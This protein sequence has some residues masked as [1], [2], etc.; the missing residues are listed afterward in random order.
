[1]ISPL[2]L[3]KFGFFL[4]SR[5]STIECVVCK[6]KLPLN[7]FENIQSDN[8]GNNDNSKAIEKSLEQCHRELCIYRTASS[9]NSFFSLPLLSS[10]QLLNGLLS[11]ASSIQNSI[12]QFQ[13]QPQI[14]LNVPSFFNLD[15]QKFKTIVSSSSSSTTT[16][17]ISDNALLLASF[18]ISLKSQQSNLLYC[19]MCQHVSHIRSLLDTS[20]KQN[21][22]NGSSSNNSRRIKY[23]STPQSPLD[24]HRWFCAWVAEGK[25]INDSNDSHDS[26]NFDSERQRLF[27]S[28][29][30]HHFPNQKVIDLQQ[31]HNMQQ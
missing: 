26:N 25:N 8:N 15:F 11:R 5:G 1:M 23:N 6:Q 20:N 29:S 24:F 27:Q 13:Q 22:E 4:P 18:G 3:A 19:E 12:N 2:L 21:F 14:I 10:E 30:S 31:D 17:V 16:T 9:P 28:I 7:T